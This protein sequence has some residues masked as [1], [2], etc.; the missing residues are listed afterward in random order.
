MQGRFW[1]L[2]SEESQLLQL[3]VIPEAILAGDSRDDF[4]PSFATEDPKDL[5]LGN[6]CDI[7][8]AMGIQP[9]R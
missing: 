8:L 5:L 4:T 9:Q 2:E 3:L 6:K 7:A 1:F